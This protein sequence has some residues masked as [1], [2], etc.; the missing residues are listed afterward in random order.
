[1]VPIAKVLSVLKRDINT[2]KIVLT[3]QRTINMDLIA[4]TVQRVVI[5]IVEKDIKEGMCIIKKEQ[6]MKRRM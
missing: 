3:V 2:N 1:M 6:I 4:T 5:D